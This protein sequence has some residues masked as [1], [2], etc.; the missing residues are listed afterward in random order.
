MLG[1][2]YGEAEEFL[3]GALPIERAEFQEAREE[4]GDFATNV[5]FSLARELKQPP[6][7]IA[8]EAVKK[9][10][11]PGESL[12]SGI[13]A[14]NGFINFFID[15]RRL[16]TLLIR[17]I[18]DK[19][20]NFGRGKHEG[21]IILEHT[22]ANPDGPLHI[23]HLRN[24]VIGDSLGRI[25]SFYGYHV[26]RQY[27]FN[28]MGKQLAMVVYGLER[29]PL[30]R[31]KKKDYAISQ[32]YVKA[33]RLCEDSREARE[34]VSR[35]IQ[36]YEAGDK[37]VREKFEKAAS[38][39]L[40]GIEETL[41]RLNIAH[42]TVTWESQF[43]RSGLARDL[44]SRLEGVKQAR[45]D[46]KALA[47][48]LS[49]FGIEKELVLRRSD[50]TLLYATRDLAHHLWKCNR[51]R[52]VNIWGADH[53]L[54]SRQL[55][56]ALSLLSIE[57]PEFVIYEFITLPSGSMSSRKGVFVTADELVEESVERAYTEVSSR[58]EGESED[59]KAEVAERVGV[60]A[61]RY[62]IVRVTPEKGIV[63]RWSEA[64]D[65]ERQGAPFIQYAYAR[66]RRMLEKAEV[67]DFDLPELSSYE[68]KLLKKLAMFPLAVE[69]SALS[70]K[71]NILANY[72]AELADSFHRF[73]MFV[74]V[75]KSEERN[76]RLSLVLAFSIVVRRGM[77]LLG[78]EALERM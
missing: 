13:K 63:F 22:S 62:N 28:D 1:R 48:N 15:Y 3:R 21:K 74:P 2:I 31:E 72:L 20:E 29:F 11:I 30:D 50:G 64:L 36:G 34:A 59:F 16:A 41:A 35:L 77:E 19:G 24:A 65:F 70:R 75:L 42:D 60:G 78:I 37:E 66:A 46:G 27:Y 7:K 9:I 76:F 12:L 69:S 54:L 73:Y 32:V 18:M 23:G 25:L 51:G 39:C 68:E 38:Y 5:C 47:L 71:P 26:E 61:V 17:E 4:Y 53:K 10:D 45:K 52:A 57:G 67:E 43:L 44:V 33:S 49:E 6:Q 58:W 56:A 55:S 8:S 14:Q 40:E